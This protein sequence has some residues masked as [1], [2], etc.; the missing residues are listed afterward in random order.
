M[1]LT[2]VRELVAA[3][4]A[5]L[6][7]VHSSPFIPDQIETLTAVIRPGRPYVTYHTAFGTEFEQSNPIV[8]LEVLMLAPSNVDQVWQAKIDDL[9]STGHVNSMVDAIEREVRGEPQLLV[10]ECD[11]WGTTAVN[12]VEYGSAYLS[13]TVLI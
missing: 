6:I 8:N 13:V 12:A 7:H 2:E 11:G 9:C 3:R 5:T 1:N 10:T 4:C